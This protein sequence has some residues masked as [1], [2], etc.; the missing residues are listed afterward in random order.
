MTP[1]AQMPALS[2]SAVLAHFAAGDMLDQLVEEAVR[3]TNNNHDAVAYSRFFAHLMRDLYE[4]GRL[5]LSA[6]R[7]ALRSLVERHRDRL[8]NRGRALVDEALSYHTLDY[9]GATRQFGAACHVDMAGPLVIH[10][11]LHT[12]GFREANRV[13]I[14]ASGDN[15]GRAV[16]L[17]AIAGALYGVGGEHG[18]PEQWIERTTLL[19]RLRGTDG[20]R[21]LLG[22]VPAETGRE[23]IAS[24]SS[25]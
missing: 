22:S 15:C 5:Q 14:L 7:D 10:I 12:E 24:R 4:A 9:R 16:M 17:G 11:L 20:G 8:G 23:A 2:R 1:A 13:N 21:L 3:M 25:R 19:E 18:I 6:A